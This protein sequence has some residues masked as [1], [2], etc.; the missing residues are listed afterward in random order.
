MGHKVIR[1]HKGPQEVLEHK[2]HKVILVQQVLTEQMVLLERPDLPGLPEL[3]AHKVKLDQQDHKDLLVLQ[4]RRAQQ[5]HKDL[6]VREQK[7][8]D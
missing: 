8:I 4:D 5:D 2:D 6:Q 1:V 3:Q 7:K